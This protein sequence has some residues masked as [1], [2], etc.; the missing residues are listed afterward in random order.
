[1]T[2]YY[3]EVS[4]QQLSVANSYYPA[5]SGDVIV[6]YQDANPRSYYQ[7]YN[8]T[9][10]PN[11]YANDTQR[12]DREHMLLKNA[13]DYIDGQNMVPDGLD[14][15]ADNDNY[16]DSVSFVVSGSSGAWASLLWPH[17]WSLYSQNAY[18]NSKRVYDYMFVLET[19]MDASTISHEMFHVLGA[20]DLYHYTNNGIDPA[21]PWDIME[22]SWKY[23]HMN[24]FMK[25]KYGG[26]I[27][28]IPELTTPGDYTLNPLSSST[29]QCYKIASPNSATEYFVVEYRKK[30]GSYED[31]IPGEGLLV[32]R[33]DPSAGNGNASGPPDEVY[34][35]RPGGATNANGDVNNANFSIEEGR[36]QISDAT[37]PDPF[38]QD[39]SAGGLELSNIGSAG[40][41]TM[42]F[43][44]GGEPP[45]T[46]AEA[47][48]NASLDFQSS[49][50]ADWTG[51]SD[52]GAVD[53]DM[54]LSGAIGNDQKSELQVSVVGPGT[55]SFAWKVSSET[56]YDYLKLEMDSELVQEISG[57]ANWA[58]VDVTIPDGVH[59]IEWSYEKD[60][61]ISE[62][63]DRA[64]VDNVT[65]TSSG[66]DSATVN[67]TP[68]F[69]LLL[70]EVVIQ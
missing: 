64:Y 25:W 8:A 34:V 65:F 70:N 42:A 28:S 46:L 69:D 52:A 47:L 2:T 41:A 63:E 12:R 4:Y 43:T 37:D 9:T 44:L 30:N 33:I 24:C 60:Y 13:I 36:T 53:G 45:M 55:L 20:P 50:D 11:G 62:G 66:G 57:E 17:R 5:P 26:W 19:H 31:G 29:N 49:G 58:Q 56:G 27:D 59:A 6:S 38:L 32:W 51:M 40:G 3:D 48:D 35:Y 10:N 1:M 39:G 54:A 15:D 21:G 67:C 61:M 7:P 23:T 16:V 14:I 68:I 22:W 18:I